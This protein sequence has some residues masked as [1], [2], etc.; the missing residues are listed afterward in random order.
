M[1]TGRATKLQFIVRLVGVLF[2]RRGS[3]KFSTSQQG[4][5]GYVLLKW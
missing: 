3:S 4:S 5:H 2:E 1:A